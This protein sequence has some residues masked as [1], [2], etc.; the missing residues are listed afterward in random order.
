MKEEQ[1]IFSAPLTGFEQSLV[2]DQGVLQPAE[3]GN[4]CRVSPPPSTHEEIWLAC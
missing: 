2:K 3:G 1:R 4:A